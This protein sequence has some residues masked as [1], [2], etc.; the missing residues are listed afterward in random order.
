MS[1]S[2]ALK[3]KQATGN[4][5]PYVAIGPRFDL[6]VNKQITGLDKQIFEGYKK[7][8]FGASVGVGTEINQ[9]FPFV[10]LVEI[11]YNQDITKSYASEFLNV[12]NRTFDLQVG[13]KL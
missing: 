1:F 8:V 6:L 5:T 7:N 3:Y 13:I 9:I 11:Q 2:P 12:T 4:L 10:F